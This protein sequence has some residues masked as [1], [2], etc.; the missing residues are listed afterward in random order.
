[1][2]KRLYIIL[3]N[4]I[5]IHSGIHGRRKNLRAPAGKERCSQHIVRNPMRRLGDH[6]SGSRRCKKDV[7]LF[8]QRH[9][10]HTILKVSVKSIHQTL[11]ARQSLEGDGIDKIRG[12]PRHNHRHIRLLLHKHTGKRGDF[13]GRN[14]ARHTKYNMF[15][16]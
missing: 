1:M 11:I 4:G 10:L 13:I 12:V 9:M 16:F 15:S 6:I 5:L 8:C 3:H 14:T 2:C 7:G